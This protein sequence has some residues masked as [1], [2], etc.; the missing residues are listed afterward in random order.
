M[1]L[2]KI[3]LNNSRIAIIVFLIVG[4]IGILNYFKI[5]RDSMPPYTIRIASVVTQY[6][7]ADSASAP[8]YWV[9]TEAIRMV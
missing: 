4:L 2:T 3:T 9:T 7:G 8:G 6:P 1:N 5:E